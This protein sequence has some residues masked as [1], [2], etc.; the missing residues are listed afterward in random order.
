MAPRLG[1]DANAAQAIHDAADGV[2]TAPSLARFFDP[3]QFVRARN[4]L[5]FSS[6]QGEVGRIDRVVDFNDAVWVLDYKLH[7]SDVQRASY[8]VQV[9]AY[10]VALQ[11][12]YPDKPVRGALIDLAARRL[13]EL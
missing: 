5:T 9:V 12:L 10:V 11:G 8:A 13:I 1:V 6:A 4:E 7:V 2:C 3:R